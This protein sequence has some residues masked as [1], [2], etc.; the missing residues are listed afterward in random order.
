MDL[1][2]EFFKKKFKTLIP[3]AFTIFIYDHFV[4]NSIVKK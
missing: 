4:Q 1:L 2:E 3:L